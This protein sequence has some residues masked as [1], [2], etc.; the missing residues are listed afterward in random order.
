MMLFLGAFDGLNS[1]SPVAEGFKAPLRPQTFEYQR[2]VMEAAGQDFMNLEL[3]SGR[4]VVQDSRRMSVISLAFTLK[5]VVM[6]AESIF[7][8]ELCRYICNSNLGQDPLEMY[9]SCIQQRGGWNNNPSAVQFRLDYRRRLFMLLCWLRKRQ[10]C[11]HSF[12]V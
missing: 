11:K 1:T 3:E 4:P 12:K 10:T 9:F 7:D 6:L 8:S 2:E 5:S